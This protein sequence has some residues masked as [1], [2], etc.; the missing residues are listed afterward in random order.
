MLD[1]IALE[2][3]GLPHEP[4]DVGVYARVAPDQKLALVRRLQERGH[5]T[6]MTGDGVNDAPALQR[7]DIGV[8]L[9][10]SGSDVARA[11][12]DLVIT[13]DDLATIVTAIREGRGIHDNLRKVVDYL[14]ASNL[15][16]VTVVIATLVL[17][18]TFGVPLFPLQLLW[19][20]L[21]TDG[22]PA[23]ALGVDPV[24][25]DLMRQPPRRSGA[26]LLD[27]P[28]VRRLAARAAVLSGGAML[29]LFLAQGAGLPTPESR[30]VIFTSLV[31]AQVLYAFVVSGR[32]ASRA[33]NRWLVLAAT[34][35]LAL[36]AVIL[37]VP[38][39]QSIFDVVTPSLPGLGAIA[40]G[41]LLPPLLL[42]AG[43]R[44]TNHP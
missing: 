6:A 9:G 23:L 11:A 20:N 19:I 25:G 41:G 31:V 44:M 33:R 16:E 17:V 39:A 14:V 40:V 35:A 36:H 28:H 2:R 1:G 30:T 10:A 38:A 27:L 42:L 24:D 8:A 3:D 22:L 34:G 4:A 29:A 15:A 32:P 18:P 37:L 26:R 43:H 12:A 5:I 7:A 13:D 21:L